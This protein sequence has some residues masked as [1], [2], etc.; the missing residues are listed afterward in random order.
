MYIAIQ[1]TRF[2]SDNAFVSKLKNLANYD[3]SIL[4]KKLA[5][6]VL[7]EKDSI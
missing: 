2:F 3:S 1:T 5:K 4:I 6:E 7:E